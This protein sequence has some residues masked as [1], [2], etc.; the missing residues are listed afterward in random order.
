[1]TG[2]IGALIFCAIVALVAVVV[3]WA[4]DTILAAFGAP[5]NVA[6]IAR[7]VVILIALLVILQK[8]LPVATS[9][10]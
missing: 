9:F 1:M 5:P 7:V 4:L 6:V 10:T 2:L 3:I 8:L